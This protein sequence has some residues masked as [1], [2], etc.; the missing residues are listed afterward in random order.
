MATP[1]L[2]NQKLIDSEELDNTNRS[3]VVFDEDHLQQTTVETQIAKEDLVTNIKFMRNIIDQY[4]YN[5]DIKRTLDP[6][7]K[8]AN[9]LLTFLSDNKKPAPSLILHP[10]EEN[11]DEINQ[12]RVGQSIYENAYK[13]KRFR[14]FLYDIR[15]L[16]LHGGTAYRRTGS[17]GQS[18]L[19]L[20]RKMDYPKDRIY[21]FL[22]G[23]AEV[24][25]YEQLFPGIRV[26]KKDDHVLELFSGAKIILYVDKM[27]LSLYSLH[28][29]RSKQGERG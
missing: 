8:T 28:W 19:C 23:A 11:K 14:S 7:I 13:H 22:D 12:R 21:Y 2:V 17:N 9:K 25:L 10:N 24:S 20:Y 18:V 4:Y 15:H 29:G 27:F 16:C 5:K 1:A 6:L 3:I 26:L